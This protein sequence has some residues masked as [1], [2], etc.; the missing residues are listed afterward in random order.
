LMNYPQCLFC[1]YDRGVSVLELG[2][3]NS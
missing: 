3:T 1:S 2:L